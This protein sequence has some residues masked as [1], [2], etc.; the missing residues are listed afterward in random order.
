[1]RILVTGGAGFQGSHVAEKW[2]RDGHSVTVL[3]TYSPEAEA[4][5]AAFADR[6]TVVWGSV[7]DREV[8]EKSVRGHDAV[9][10]LAARINVDD[11]V[12]NPRDYIDVNVV[13]TLNVLEAVRQTGARLI[14]A[15]SC[16]V[17]GYSERS[18]VS[19]SA[20]LQPYSPYAASKAGAD[21]LC[22]AYHK[23]YGVDV[24]LIR[25]CNIYGERQKSGRGGAV[26]PIFTNLASSGKPLTVFGAGTQ[27]REYLHV[28]DLV[29]AYD[30][31]LQRSDLSGAVLNAGTG[32]TPSV[33]EIARFICEKTGAT[34]VNGPPRPGEVPGFELDSS[35][36]RGL[37]FSPRIG[38][39]DGLARYLDS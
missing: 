18:P 21:R 13:G 33:M 22:F 38:F 35:T 25:P 30:L 7:T 20:P 1:M 28:E 34:V 4:N 32:V 8:V 10:H 26:I 37:G 19:E 3:N 9:A 5:I 2:V 17:Y 23:T 15:S 39:W 24:T 31:V 16:E 11:S 36:I 27:R 6:V 29:D 14:F 12:A